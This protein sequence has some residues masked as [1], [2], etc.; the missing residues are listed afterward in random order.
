MNCYWIQGCLLGFE[1]DWDLKWITINLFCLKLVLH[2][3]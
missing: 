2:Y 3:K 1:W